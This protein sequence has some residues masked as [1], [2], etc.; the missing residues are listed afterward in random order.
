MYFLILYRGVL[1]LFTLRN[2]SYQKTE[3]APFRM[4]I[5]SLKPSDIKE[6]V[7]I[8]KT[9]KDRLVWL[10]SLVKKLNLTDAVLY[11]TLRGLVLLILNS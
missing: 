6:N 3:I 1:D 9:L 10:D 4:V 7:I 11:N 2:K 8:F 5:Q